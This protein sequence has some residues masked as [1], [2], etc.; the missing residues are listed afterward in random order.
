V[1]SEPVE[2]RDIMPTVLSIAGVPVPET[3]EGSSLLPLTAGSAPEWRRYIHGEH[4]TCYGP[5]QEMQ[6]V[7]DGRHKLIWFPR[8]GEEQFFD[9]EEDPEESRNLVA[10]PERK[11]ELV[12]WRGYLAAELAARDCGWVRDG[13]PYCAHD[14]PLVSPYRDLRWPGVH[15]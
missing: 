2:L 8:T 14:G 7:T 11:D 12:L 10:L 3:V 5:E 6:Y 4:C 13:R 9:L 15:T 1:A